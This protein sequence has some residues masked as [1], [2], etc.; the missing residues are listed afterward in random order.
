MQQL[1][2]SSELR[3]FFRGKS[4]ANSG[5]NSGR[6]HFLTKL[7]DDLTPGR[8]FLKLKG[9]PQK[10]QK[11]RKARK[12]KKKLL[13]DNPKTSP[14]DKVDGPTKRARPNNPG[15]VYTGYISWVGWHSREQDWSDRTLGNVTKDKVGERPDQEVANAEVGTVWE[16]GIVGE[17]GRTIAICAYLNGGTDEQLYYSIV[18]PCTSPFLTGWPGRPPSAGPAAHPPGPACPGAAE[19]PPGNRRARLPV[20]GGG[21]G[22]RPARARASVRTQAPFAERRAPLLLPPP[23]QIP[24]TV[25]GGPTEV[26]PVLTDLC[27][28]P[29]NSW[30]Y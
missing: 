12:S 27:R 7:H 13:V 24:P 17:G 2:S 22:G 21:G 6:R 16:G 18:P 25:R 3:G 14:P 1:Q 8:I 26:G 11:T 23:V 30:I 19:V 9:G 20:E 5:T 10:Q 29:T 28:C 15:R 4:V